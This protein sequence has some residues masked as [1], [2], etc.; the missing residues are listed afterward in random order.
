[1]VGDYTNP[2]LRPEAAATIKKIARY[3][4]HRQIRRTSP[5]AAGGRRDI[6]VGGTSCSAQPR[7]DRE[8]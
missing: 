1:V 8:P 2:S 3:C 7:R 4:G 6:I 5:V